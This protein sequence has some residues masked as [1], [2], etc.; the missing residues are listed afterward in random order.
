MC[1]YFS[2]VTTLENAAAV[3]TD[4]GGPRPQ[5]PITTTRWTAGIWVGAGLL[6]AYVRDPDLARSAATLLTIV[7]GSDFLH[8]AWAAVD[9]R[10]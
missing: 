7:A 5:A 4:S 8:Q 1:I 10:A 6:A 3:T 2:T 9:K